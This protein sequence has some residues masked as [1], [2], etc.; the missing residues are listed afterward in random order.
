M[1]N[2]CLKPELVMPTAIVSM[3]IVLSQALF[4]LGFLIRFQSALGPIRLECKRPPIW[5]NPD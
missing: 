1:H 5:F 2:F 3:V 4:T